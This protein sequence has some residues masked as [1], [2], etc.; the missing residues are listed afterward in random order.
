MTQVQA[1]TSAGVMTVCVPVT[2]LERPLHPA[3]VAHCTRCGE[4]VW[5]HRPALVCADA[6][7]RRQTGRRAKPVCPDCAAAEAYRRG[8][9][10]TAKALADMAASMARSAA[11]ERRSGRPRDRMHQ[12]QNYVLQ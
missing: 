2:A 3:G 7:S 1:S 9:T 5:F 10:G 6:M 12:Q 11:T 8:E 4:L